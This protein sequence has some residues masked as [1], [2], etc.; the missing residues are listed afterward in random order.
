M[1]TDNYQIRKTIR[2]DEIQDKKLNEIIK[3]KKLSSVTEALRIAIDYLYDGMKD[4]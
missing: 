3:R 1:R 4:E 2:I